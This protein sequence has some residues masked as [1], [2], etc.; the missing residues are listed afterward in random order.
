MPSPSKGMSFAKDPN[1]RA[2]K[3]A[4]AEI[5]IAAGDDDEIYVVGEIVKVHRDDTV[6]VLEGH[7]FHRIWGASNGGRGTEH[8]V[9]TSEVA[10]PNNANWRRIAWEGVYYFRKNQ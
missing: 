5:K 4:L 6:T 3:G 7:A 1:W 9:R 10:Q 2:R 8:R